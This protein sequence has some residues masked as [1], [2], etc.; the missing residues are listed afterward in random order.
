MKFQNYNLKFNKAKYGNNVLAIQVMDT[1]DGA[2]YAI[3]SVNMA[4]QDPSDGCFWM[5]TWSENEELSKFVVQA[6]YVELTGKIIQAGYAY[7][8]EAKLTKKGEEQIN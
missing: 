4:D 2:P 6:G 1:E 7:A 5:K 8:Y 3:L